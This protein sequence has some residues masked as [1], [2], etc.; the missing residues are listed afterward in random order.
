M[1]ET[2]YVPV[3]VRAGKLTIEQRA[4]WDD[5]I[6]QLPDCEGTV[7]FKRQRPSKSLEALG[8][9]YGLVFPMIAEDTGESLD[10]VKWEMKKRFLTVTEEATNT[11]TGEVRFIER[12]KSIG[13]LNSKELAEF[14]DQ[15]VLEAAEGFGIVVPPP[16]KRW[17]EKAR[18]AA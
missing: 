10:V 6:R 14:T 11:K 5:A 9:L 2:F 7:T 15:V 8:Y 4:Y 16:D 13:E 3:R 1:P 18:H 17:R 12:V